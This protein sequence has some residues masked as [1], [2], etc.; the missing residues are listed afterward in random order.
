MF[1][2]YLGQISGWPV[3]LCDTRFLEYDNVIDL[4]LPTDK[5]AAAKLHVH[6]YVVKFR[7]LNCCG[8]P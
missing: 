4:E 1:R 3:D 6:V 8:I 5:I 7:E 2:T